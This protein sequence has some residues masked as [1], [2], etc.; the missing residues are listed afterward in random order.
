MRASARRALGVGLLLACIVDVGAAR[1]ETRVF[2]IGDDDGFG[3]GLRAGGARL[4]SAG[5]FDNREADDPSFTDVRPVSPN[6]PHG[7]SWVHSID[8]APGALVALELRL[9]AL[10]IQDGDDDVTGVD[11]EIRLWIEGREVPGAFDEVDQAHRDGEDLVETVGLVTVRVTGA[12]VAE[13]AGDIADGE[14]ELRFANLDLIR[15]LSGDAF[16]IDWAELVVE[17]VAAGRRLPGDCNG[18]TALSI[19]DALCLLGHLFLGDP[20]LESPCAAGGGEAVLDFDGDAALG[21]DDA[22]GVLEHLFRGGRTHHL[23]LACVP[24]AGCEDACGE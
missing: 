3:I 2:R 19:S 8:P 21:L 9:L 7:F 14:V 4:A 16:A 24:V 23:G 15:P 6:D 20:A 10:G 18:D 13:L 17:T 12:L 22:I 11:R 5:F 1:G